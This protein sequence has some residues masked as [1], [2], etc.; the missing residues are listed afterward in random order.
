[1][2]LAENR[3]I[4]KSTRPNAIVEGKDLLYTLTTVSTSTFNA[5]NFS[6]QPGLS[7]IFPTLSLDAKRWDR[8]RFKSLRFILEPSTGVTTTPGTSW[9]LWDPNPTNLAPSDMSVVAASEHSIT[10]SVWR[11]HV[12]NIPASKLSTWKYTRY[13][14]Q[15]P[16]LLYDAGTITLGTAGMS[17]SVV[18]YLRAEYTIE[19]SDYQYGASL[20]GAILGTTESIYDQSLAMVNVT[21]LSYPTYRAMPS[22]FE[23][24]VNTI[25]AGRDFNGL[26]RQ[27]DT[28][29]F[30]LPPG[31]Y[32][33][34]YAGRTDV[35]IVPS[36]SVPVLW[37]LKLSFTNLSSGTLVQTN[38]LG[39]PASPPISSANL[40]MGDSKS[41]V[42]TIAV[43]D[44][45]RVVPTYSC[46]TITGAATSNTNRISGTIY[47]RVVAV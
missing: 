16:L 34:N 11:T 17:S 8:Y 38:I 39:G 19:F 42:I 33:I 13:G 26:L 27:T 10:G 14:P 41:A 15:S 22:P 43:N 40:P 35:S 6:V 3:S 9:M 4:G 47:I 12:L 37:N 31:Q 18:L 29:D 44:F 1:M 24:T 23:G 32:Q 2:P 21:N 30:I 28:T 36:S 25:V 45:T 5:T 20:G 7:N 46:D